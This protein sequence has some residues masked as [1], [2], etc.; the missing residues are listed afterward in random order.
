MLLPM[1]MTPGISNFAIFYSYTFVIFRL[2]TQF[3]FYQKKLYCIGWCF[4]VIYVFYW[5]CGIA[6][7]VQ[8]SIYYTLDEAVLVV[9]ALL[10]NSKGGEAGAIW[11]PTATV[12]RGTHTRIPPVPSL[13]LPGCMS[14]PIQQLPLATS[15][16]P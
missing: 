7:G 3:L 1:F 10:I 5:V 14:Y 16:K 15:S 11:P 6:A 2:S 4:F 9:P 8:S 12:I 13:L